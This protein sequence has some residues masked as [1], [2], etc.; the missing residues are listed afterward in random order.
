L[1]SRFCPVSKA[2]LLQ[3]DKIGL[4]TLSPFQW[5]ELAKT[6]DSKKME[7]VGEFSLMV[8]NDKAH[9]WVYGITS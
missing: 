1:M 4:Y 6:G 5:E 2:F 3:S 7:V 9:A 8:A